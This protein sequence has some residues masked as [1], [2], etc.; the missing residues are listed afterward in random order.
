MSRRPLRL[1]FAPPIAEYGL[2][3]S[4]GATLGEQLQAKVAAAAEAEA[5]ARGNAEREQDARQAAEATVKALR[6]GLD[7]ATE[8]RTHAEAR[9][10]TLL[11]EEAER[12][13]ARRLELVD[14]AEARQLAQETLAQALANA[15]QEVRQEVTQQLG[16]LQSRLAREEE[17]VAA[18]N[19]EL[20]EARHAMVSL[21]QQVCGRVVV[22][23][24]LVACRCHRHGWLL[25][26]AE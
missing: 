1:L 19:T 14:A 6:S 22:N 10:Q 25:M 23:C 20:A 16:Q 24:R 8:A 13:E 5:I 2:H 26:T 17:R 15:E 4:L 7:A 12:E 3:G 9:L 21:S 11:G 18:L